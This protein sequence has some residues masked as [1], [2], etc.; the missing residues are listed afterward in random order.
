MRRSITVILVLALW[1]TQWL[2]AAA[3]PF[4][5]LALHL[6]ASTSLTLVLQTASG[7]CTL[8]NSGS[9]WAAMDMGAASS[10]THTAACVTYNNGGSYQ[11][12]TNFAVEATC[13]GTCATQW[14]LSVALK[15]ASQ[16]G[17]QWQIDGSNVNSTTLSQCGGG[18]QH[19]SY[20]G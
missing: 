8:V 3:S 19:L 15:S 16:A 4:T 18:C 10:S 11:M 17:L 12:Q 13:S 20:W 14:N 9:N 7:G 2:S 6:L 5:P 1:A